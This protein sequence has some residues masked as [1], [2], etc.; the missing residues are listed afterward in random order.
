MYNPL[1]KAH[2]YP[3]R[4]WYRDRWWGIIE[5]CFAG[6]VGMLVCWY[7]YRPL[8]VLTTDPPHVN[9]DST[10]MCLHRWSMMSTV[11]WRGTLVFE[12]SEMG[13]PLLAAY[14]HFQCHDRVVI[15]LPQIRKCCSTC[16]AWTCACFLEQGNWCAYKHSPK[17]SVVIGG[18][19]IWICLR[20]RRAL[21][22]GGQNKLSQHSTECN[23][24]WNSTS[25]LVCFKPHRHGMAQQY[26][27]LDPVCYNI[28]L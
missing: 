13:K 23:L 14:P 21:F 16:M 28:A 11:L 6:F 7:L 4:R 3:R 8:T 12:F 27:Y 26:T 25:G 1:D 19:R 5:Y 9:S 10:R 17:I 15:D 20:K 22:R 18:E 2:V 24:M